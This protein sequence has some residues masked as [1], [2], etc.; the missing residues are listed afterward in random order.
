VLPS[1]LEV[2]AA[3]SEVIREFVKQG[4]A[5]YMSVCSQDGGRSV[6]HPFLLS[7]VLGVRYSDRPTETYNYITPVHQD[8]RNLIW[9]QDHMAYPGPLVRGVAAPS[10]EV[11]ATITPPFV[12]PESGTTIGSRFGAFWSNPPALQPGEDPA[13]VMHSF[14]AG[15]AIWTAG[16]METIDELVNQKLIVWL[17]RRALEKPLQFEVGAPRW[18]EMTLYDQR[19]EGRLIASLL[20]LQTDELRP[21]TNA[22][23]KVRPPRGRRILSVKRVPTLE[24]I[25]A[26]IS[27]D[28]AEFETGPFDSFIMFVL[29]YA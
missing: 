8:L 6:G 29:E 5:L 25:S 1:V 17:L 19:A 15:R 11:L 14:G 10:T 22:S 20:N 3:Q 12:A 23:V 28:G 24:R 16:P 2:R 21:P 27:G 26:T 4:G 9:P 13:I 18:V 7:D